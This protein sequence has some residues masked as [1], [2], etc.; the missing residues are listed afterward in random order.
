MAALQQSMLEST[1]NSL[2]QEAALHQTMLES[3]RNCLERDAKFNKLST[4][5]EFDWWILQIRS[6]LAHEAW[7]GILDQGEPC[8]TC[9]ENRSL[10]NKLAQRLTACMTATVGDAIGG[11]DGHA[12]KGMEML[13][14]IIDHFIPSAVVNLPTIFR[15]WSALHQ[16]NDELAVVFSGRVVKL[17]NRS[18]RAGQD[19]TESSKILTFVG[20]LHNG[21]ADFA[22]DYFS[23]RTCLSETTLRDTTA[24]AKTLE[25]TMEENHEADA[26]AG[27]LSDA[28]VDAL[29]DNFECP[30]CRAQDH[31]LVDCLAYRDQ[32]Y[33]FTEAEAEHPD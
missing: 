28:Q 30:L 23:G 31:S 5:D 27:P 17:A 21:F 7:N 14:S 13:Q 26:G 1:R 33:I 11:M 24:L 19:F 20:G 32:G 9:L 10:S 8:T 3:N 2:E 29:F 22:K 6:R 15:E 12:G 16:E 25:L 4:P 18:K